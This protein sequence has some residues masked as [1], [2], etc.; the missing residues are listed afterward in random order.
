M[1]VA[2][3]YQIFNHQKYGG[4]SRY[5]C[6]LARRIDRL[7]NTQARVVAGWHVNDYLEQCG[8]D[9]TVG[10]RRPQIRG[11]ERWLNSASKRCN[12]Y[13]SDAHFRQHPTD[14]VHYT[15]YYPSAQ[16]HGAT[17]VLTVYDMIHD[18]LSFRKYQARFTRIL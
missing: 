7:P 6:E 12:K 2:Y 14:I 3:D 10:R 4:I 16:S 18:Y 9:L 15:F 5:F 11:L 8:A 17:G 13:W 1:N